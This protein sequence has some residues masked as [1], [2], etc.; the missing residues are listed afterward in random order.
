MGQDT[1]G[2][3]DRATILVADADATA[4][5]A[6]RGLDIGCPVEVEVAP[7][8]RA[9]LSRVR[10]NHV[11]VLVLDADLP[12]GPA[13]WVLAQ[14]RKAKPSLHVIY[15]AAHPT[16][17][18]ELRARRLGI[19]YFAPKP[20]DGPTLARVLKS[21]IDHDT[22]KYARPSVRSVAG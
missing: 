3:E 10:E 20:L 1:A 11:R 12:D 7:S 8:A 4:V 6:I 14:V 21:A 9:C 19:L 18:V 16:D 17:E 15:T 5:A 22:R 2:C 13:E